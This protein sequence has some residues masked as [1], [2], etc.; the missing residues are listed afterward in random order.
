MEIALQLI[1]LFGGL[2]M[3]LFGM[4]T[5]STGL[6]RASGDK[7]RKIMEKV[8]GNMIKS[9][10][11]GA[12]VA[13]LTQSS[14]ATTVMVVGFVNAG[15][16]TLEQSVGIIMGANIGTTIT[17][18]IISLNDIPGGTW[19]LDLIKPDTLAPI[20]LIVG[21]ALMFFS[22]GDKKKSTI[23]EFIVGFGIL[24]VGMQFMSSSMNVVFEQVPALKRLFEVGSNPVVGILIGAGVTAV[25]Q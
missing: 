9:V 8:T 21:A 4:N 2:G 6:E 14:S 17:A 3:F 10:A 23:G 15:L 1:S 13:A 7:M 25:I 22:G 18:W 16:L 11:L 24:F 12:V 19:Y 20:A 5:M